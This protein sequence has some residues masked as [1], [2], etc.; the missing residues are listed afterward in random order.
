MEQKTYGKP[1]VRHYGDIRAL[2]QSV[3]KDG[4]NSDGIIGYLLGVPGFGDQDP[5]GSN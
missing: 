2:T 3:F 4:S 1:V 5:G